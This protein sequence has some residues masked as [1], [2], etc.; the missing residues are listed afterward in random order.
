MG[1]RTVAAHGEFVLYW[2]RTAVR[3]TENPALDVA[4]EAANQLGLP[5]FV[6]HGLSEKYPFASDRH[7]TF[8]LQGAKDVRASLAKRNIGYAFHLEIRDH[9]GPW[10]VDLANRAAIVVTEDMPVEPLVGWTQRLSDKTS[11]PLVAVDTACVL[12]MQEVEK[13]YTRAFEFRD[14]T[15]GERQE[16]MLQESRD[17]EPR[18]TAFV[19]DDLP[20]EPVDFE[21]LSIDELVA[22]CDID[23]SVGPVPDTVGG[24]LAGYARW[25]SFV[26]SGLHRYAKDRNNAL[27]PGVSRMSAYLHYGMVSP[28]RIAREAAD[29]GGKG[30]EKYLD[31]LLIWR[32][33]AY[34]FCFHRKDHDRL[35]AIPKWARESLS[36]HE[37]DPRVQLPSWET[38]AR[39]RTKVPLWDAAQHSLL[40]HGELH[41]NVRMTWGKAFL[42]WTADAESAWRLMTDLNHRYALDGRDPASFGGLLWC[43]G[44]FDRPFKPPQPIYGTVRPRPIEA[45]AERLEP[46]AYAAHCT[47]SYVDPMPNIAVIGAGLSG[48]IC[49]RTLVDHGFQ[50]TVFEKSRGVGGRMSTR[51]VEDVGSFDHGAQYFTVRDERF[52]RSVQS[53]V[54]DRIVEPWPGKIAVLRCADSEEHKGRSSVPPPNRFVAKPGM[55]QIAKHLATDLQVRL[56]TRVNDVTRSANGWTVV[57]EADNALGVFD[58]VIVSAPAEQTASILKSVPTIAAPAANCQ[59]QPCWAVMIALKNTLAVDFDGAFVHNSS[60]SWI[61]RNSGK[62][63]RRAD[64]EKWILHATTEWTRAHEN[65]ERETVAA[66]LIA[67]LAKTV[68]V[69]AELLATT[70]KTAHFWRYAIPSTPLSDKCL[71]DRELS[72]GACGDWCGGP[73]VEGAFLSGAALAG[74]VL[75]DWNS[76]WQRDGAASSNAP[77]QQLKLF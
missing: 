75:G 73:R 4:V 62:P 33:L 24:S 36:S 20:F 61:A 21:S 54:D 40:I 30:A 60:L 76:R 17:L 48:L 37:T 12:P 74:R 55:N 49:A 2:M 71:F 16:R 77:S 43:L 38:L 13:A 44:Q 28:M 1:E 3:A 64:P 39:G 23:H 56:R 50:V 65:T 51:R 72:V 27:L 70:Y 41:N 66:K 14:A 8:I 57:D 26:K 5:V 67:E 52:H 19:P 6:Y 25:N 10:I 11:T 9:R 18:H 31:E 53:W 15:A 63:G 45:H 69:R 34:A 42:S 7:H 68:G 22:L 29:I 59:M 47:R 35:D 46:A 58:T 32:E